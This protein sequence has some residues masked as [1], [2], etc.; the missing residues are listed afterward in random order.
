MTFCKTKW[1]IFLMFIVYVKSQT[2]VG[3][4]C[5]DQFTNTIGRCTAAETC[6][7]ARRDFQQNGIRPTFC[8]YSAFGTTLVCCRDG[9]NILQTADPKPI[10]PIWGSTSNKQT[11]QRRV[12]E[13]KCEEYS[14][15]V[16]EKVD[17]I[18]LLPDPETMSISAAKCEYTGVELIVGGE[19]ANQGEFPHMAALGWANF[20]GGYD[21]SCGGSLISTKY[22]LSAGHCTRNPRARD[23]APA[24]VRLGDQNIDPSVVDGAN[25]IEVPI[26]STLSHPDYK[27]PRRYND[28]ALFEL[29]SDVTFSA[30]IRP[31]CLWSRSDLGGHK[32]ALAT[33]WGVTDAVTKQTSKELQK[34]SLSLLDNNQCDQL[35]VSSRNRHWGGFQQS[36]MCAGELRGGKDTCQGDSG[37]PLQVT[38]KD[39]QCIFHI[40]GI[41][42]FGRKC[43]ESGMPAVYTR[44]SSY[45]DWIESVVWPGE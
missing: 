5:V 15:G 40:I 12:S 36:Q 39:N 30:T 42:S 21:F 1:Q 31:A 18:P 45:V 29:A 8:T 38:S 7:S 27:P 3:D 10:R 19:N 24:I 34:V 22:V 2:K 28:I 41:T 44:V 9:T 35:L 14:R 4:S 32:K 43:A 23:P 11:D 16:V 33:G 26:K 6:D 25:P 13:R 17:F 20:E 37:S